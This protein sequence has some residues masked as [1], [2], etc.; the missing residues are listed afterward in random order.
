[1]L[2]ARTIPPSAA[3]IVALPVVAADDESTRSLDNVFVH[4]R[5]LDSAGD[6]GIGISLDQKVAD[7]LS[8]FGRCGHQTRDR[9]RFDR[10]LTSGGELAGSAWA[11]GAESIGLA[12]GRPRTSA[13]YHAEAP[14]T[15]GHAAAGHEQ[16]L[17]VH[18]RYR[19]TKTL[20]LSPDLQWIRLAG[21]DPAAATIKIVGL[22]AR[23]GI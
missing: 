23:L 21:G 8:L 13:A 20:D 5:L 7:A 11:R 9:A 12:L 1:M 4:D 18:Y 19:L 17:E 2:C 15:G 6:T 10:A 3:A 14:A 22:R 16:Q